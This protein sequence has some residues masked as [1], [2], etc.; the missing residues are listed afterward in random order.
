MGLL[1]SI[2]AHPHPTHPW[3]S[4]TNI[5]RKQATHTRPNMANQKVRMA[6]CYLKHLSDEQPYKEFSSLLQ[7]TAVKKSLKR[8][9]FGENNVLH[10]GNSQILSQSNNNHN[11]NNKT[12]KIVWKSKNRA[13]FIKQKLLVYKRRPQNSLNF[14]LCPDLKNSPFKEFKNLRKH[15]K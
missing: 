11:P 3:E 6:L 15:R 4:T 12:T 13:M 1:F 5:D 9:Y 14:E 10:F 8:K 2:P 7:F